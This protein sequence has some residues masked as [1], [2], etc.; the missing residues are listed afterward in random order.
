MSS[1]KEHCHDHVF[2]Q[3]VLWDFS[4]RFLTVF[5]SSNA[6]MDWSM[7]RT[8]LGLEFCRVPQVLPLWNHQLW[9]EI[10]DGKFYRAKA[11]FA[12]SIKS[13]CVVELSWTHRGS[14]LKSHNLLQER[15]PSLP[16]RK[17]NLSPK[18]SFTLSIPGLSQGELTHQKPNEKCINQV[19]LSP[20][21]WCFWI[22]GCGPLSFL[23]L[24]III[25]NLCWFKLEGLLYICSAESFTCSRHSK[26]VHIHTDIWLCIYI[27]KSFYL[28]SQGCAHSFKPTC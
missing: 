9:W 1:A 22:F 11:H 21:S 28:I 20:L 6:C 27:H 14:L 10:S 17:N 2:C 19:V 8:T 5:H 18:F 7:V 26:R 16:Y 15:S 23:L 3:V 4:E 12:I 25:M 24:F 13:S